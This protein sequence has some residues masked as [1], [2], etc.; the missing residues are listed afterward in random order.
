[1]LGQ[2]AS[3]GGFACEIGVPADQCKF[4]VIGCGLDDGEHGGH[5]VI[6]GSERATAPGAIDDPWGVLKDRT[7]GIDKGSTIAR[8]ESTDIHLVVAVP[9]SRAR[10]SSIAV[11]MRS[12]VAGE[13][14]WT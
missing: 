14:S 6:S 10:M 7:E 12:G 2:G 9:P 13:F 11:R 5:K 1:M 3:T 8:I 4:L